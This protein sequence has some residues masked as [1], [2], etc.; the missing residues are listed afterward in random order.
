MLYGPDHFESIIICMFCTNSY[1]RNTWPAICSHHYKNIIY[2][3]LAIYCKNDYFLKIWNCMLL[4]QI[5]ITITN[6]SS[7]I[8][9]FLACM[10]DWSLAVRCM[11]KFTSHFT[12]CTLFNYCPAGPQKTNII[13]SYILFICCTICAC[14]TFYDKTGEKNIDK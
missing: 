10:I 5:I 8:R 6:N 7:Q 14:M 12:W 11:E 13:C 4:S 2:L 9:I 1:I 3:W